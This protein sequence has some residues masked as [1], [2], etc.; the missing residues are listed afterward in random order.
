MPV[1]FPVFLALSLVGS[2]GN[3]FECNKV[4]GR[5]VSRSHL[6]SLVNRACSD[7]IEWPKTL[8]WIVSLEISFDQGQ[9]QCIN[10]AWED[11]RPDL[12]WA[13]Q[14]RQEVVQSRPMFG[15]KVFLSRLTN[16]PVL[17]KYRPWIKSKTQRD[18]CRPLA[19]ATR[20]FS[21]IITNTKPIQASQIHVV[22]FK[23]LVKS[24]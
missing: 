20:W 21:E 12:R 8:S 9:P 16:P 4:G 14:V 17:G 6:N 10:L 22:N 1:W 24:V 7:T 19:K 5:G 18:Q 11:A 13:A 23:G 15:T 2:K 3:V